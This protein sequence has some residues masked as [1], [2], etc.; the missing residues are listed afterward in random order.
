[1]EVCVFNL[2]GLKLEVSI[3]PGFL[4]SILLSRHRLLN[5]DT[6][7]AFLI[8]R[9]ACSENCC[10]SLKISCPALPN[11]SLAGAFGLVDFAANRCQWDQAD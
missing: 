8:P 6:I 3:P 1:M 7:T 11:G 10:T 4:I 9:E 2:L 5:P